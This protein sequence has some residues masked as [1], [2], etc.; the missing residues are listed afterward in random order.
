M[1]IFFDL[2]QQGQ[3]AA[4]TAK[5]DHAKNENERLKSQIQD[6]QRKSDALTI[7]C[8][9]LWEIVRD[10]AGMADEAMIAKLQEIDLRDG[11]ADGKIST[12]LT[13]CPSCG[14]RSN[15]NRKQCLYC[16]ASMPVG[17]I[18]GRA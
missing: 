1:N 13:A 2:Y 11:Q 12:T 18:F 3:I 17:Q 10:R 7:A 15:S 4:A 14:R 8:Q 5:A 9:A 16:G 6:L